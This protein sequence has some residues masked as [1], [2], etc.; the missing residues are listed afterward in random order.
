MALYQCCRAN[1]TF[2]AALCS[3]GGSTSGGAAQQ[4]W[5]ILLDSA[6]RKEPSPSLDQ[7]GSLSSSPAGAAGACAGAAGADA[8]G[9]GAGAN[10][11]GAGAAGAGGIAEWLPLLVSCI[12]LRQGLLWPLME[13]L[14][15]ESQR[16]QGRGSAEE[17]EGAEERHGATWSRGS[18]GLAEGGGAIVGGRD[19]RFR[20]I[21]IPEEGMLPP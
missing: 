6:L 21:N 5:G 3:A 15:E 17:R 1:A 10:G 13:C 11:A 9:P 20:V 18:P 2:S 14:S 8:T 12:T 4:V 19:G 16:A 7:E